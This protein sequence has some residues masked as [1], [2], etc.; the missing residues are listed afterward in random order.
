MESDE[1]FSLSGLTQ[2]TFL[3][4][5]FILNDELSIIAS[6]LVSENRDFV[7]YKEPTSANTSHAESTNNRNISLISAAVKFN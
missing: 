7:D 3:P 4:N 5:R 1:N 2:N 6:I